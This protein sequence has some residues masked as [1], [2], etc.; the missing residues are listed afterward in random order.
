M[1]RSTANGSGI[2]FLDQALKNGVITAKSKTKTSK[3]KTKTKT[4]KKSRS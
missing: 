1:Y 3:A 2:S 4:N